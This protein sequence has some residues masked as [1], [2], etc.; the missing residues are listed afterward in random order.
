MSTDDRRN[1]LST[2]RQ[3]LGRGAAATSPPGAHPGASEDAASIEARAA[4]I[5][6]EARNNADTLLSQLQEAA[7]HAGWSVARV[8]SADQ[9]VKHIVRIAQDL[10]ARSIVRSA[11]EALEGLDLEG[12]MAR[13]GITLHRAVIDDSVEEALRQQQRAIIRDL[14]IN[15]DIGLTGVDHAI[16]ETGSVV[17][18]PRRGVSRVVS[19][20]PPVHVADSAKEIPTD[21]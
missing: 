16:A 20:L 8:E 10:E 6:Q 12:P 19:L 3:A 5:L 21:Y 4:E 15:A 1:F 14:C 7:G 2:V 13:T 17:L 9:A 18:L 11:H